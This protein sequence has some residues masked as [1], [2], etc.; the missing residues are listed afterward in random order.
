MT[1]RAARL[2][3]RVT[4][5]YRLACAG[6]EIIN[7]FPGDPETFTLGAGEIDPRLEALITGLMPGTR[8][9][10]LL[11]AWQAFG[12]RDEAL[13]QDLD[14]AEFKAGLDLKPGLM[15][16][17]DLPNGQTL[18]GTIVTLDATKVRID[19]NHPLAGLPVEFEVE[20]LSVN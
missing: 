17:F 20:L 10:H 5:H 1:D 3:D 19:F 15:A 11:Q 6:R 9:L 16:N 18:A 14:R 12:E 13:V 2:G 8:Q 4:L 7:T